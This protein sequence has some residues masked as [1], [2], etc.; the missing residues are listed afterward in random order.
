EGV[1]EVIG[2]RHPPACTVCLNAMANGRRERR[3]QKIECALTGEG[4]KCVDVDDAADSVSEPV[5]CDRHGHA[6]VAGT[7]EH[8][9]FKSLELDS[10]HDVLD[11]RRK[12]NP[13]V[14]AQM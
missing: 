4:H 6:A 13:L 10:C 9:A 7:A 3:G 14:E 12:T 1:D 2:Y 5:R 8:D 11:V